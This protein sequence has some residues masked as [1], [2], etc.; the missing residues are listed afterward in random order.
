MHQG[1]QSEENEITIDG[2]L[3]GTN[4]PGESWSGSNG[5]EL[6]LTIRCSLVSYL[7]H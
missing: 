1:L 3:T 5:N 6:E 7:G 4:I 2:T